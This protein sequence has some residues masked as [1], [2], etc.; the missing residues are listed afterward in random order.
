M[1]CC[2]TTKPAVDKVRRVGLMSTALVTMLVSNVAL[3]TIICGWFF[4]GAAL[5]MMSLSILL[6]KLTK[7]SFGIDDYLTLLAFAITIALVV[8]T[9]GAI[10]EE[11]FGE[12]KSGVSKLNR[13]VLVKV[14]HAMGIG[15][16]PLLR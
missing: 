3:V 15:E 16:K 12:H 14:S 1:R 13:A 10:H 5:Q 11:G 9:M 8:H 2:W 6:R 7:R 4:V